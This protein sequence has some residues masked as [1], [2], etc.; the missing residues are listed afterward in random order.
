MYNFI[1]TSHSHLAYLAITAI[2][3]ALIVNLITLLGKKPYGKTENLTALIALILVYVQLVLGLILYFTSP[4]GFN[5]LGSETMNNGFELKHTLGS[6]FGLLILT[7]I[8]ANQLEKCLN[9]AV[10]IFFVAVC[11]LQIL[12]FCTPYVYI[13]E[14]QGLL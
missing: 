14:R 1:K 8:A 4:Y 2:V 12:V 6:I 7:Q 3:V 5:N 11:V 9:T 10:L 13:L